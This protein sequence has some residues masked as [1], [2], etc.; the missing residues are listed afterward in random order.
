MPAVR[1]PGAPASRSLR[2]SRLPPRSPRP[3]TVY[4]CPSCETRYL[5]EQRCPDCGIFCRRV[6]PGGPCPHCDEPVALDRS[7]QHGKRRWRALIQHPAQQDVQ[8]ASLTCRAFVPQAWPNE[9]K[10]PTDRP[11]NWRSERYR[12]WAT[13]EHQSG[14]FRVDKH[15][16]GRYRR[17]GRLRGRDSGQSRGRLL[18]PDHGGGGLRDDRHGGR[19]GPGGGCRTTHARDERQQPEGNGGSS[20]DTAERRDVGRNQPRCRGRQGESKAADRCEQATE[21]G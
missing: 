7:R 14:P 2:S 19:G 8:F 6:G 11:P 17:S 4:E 20:W 18:G 15:N 10:R 5:G 9:V 16:G 21:R 13:P 1:P 3:A 12:G